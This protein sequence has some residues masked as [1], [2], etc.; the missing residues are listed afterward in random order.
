M[1]K[2]MKKNGLILFLIMAALFLV[3]PETNAMLRQVTNPSSDAS[4]SGSLPWAVAQINAGG[5]SSNTIW[6]NT[7]GDSITVYSTLVINY[8]TT[9][10]SIA[11][12][13][14]TI[15]TSNPNSMELFRGNTNN[16]NFY[17]LNIVDS[18][19]GIHIMPGVWNCLIYGCRIGTDETNAVNR[20]NKLYGIL[21]EGNVTNIGQ[22]DAGVINVISN[23][24]TAGIFLRKADK[25]LIRNS[26]IGTNN[27]GTAALG[28]Q[29]YGVL[30]QEGAV[31]CRIGGNYYYY[32]GN[33][34]SGN[35]FGISI[36]DVSSNTC[37][38]NS[39]AGNIIGLRADQSAAIPNGTGVRLYRCKENSVGAPQ[40][41]N[42]NVISGNSNT[43]VLLTDGSGG[44]RPNGNSISNNFIGT[45]R[46]GEIR[47][48]KTGIEIINGD[49]NQIGGNRQG[50]GPNVVAGNAG[51]G[52]Q[53]GIIIN[54]DNNNIIG[55][56]V[57]VYMNTVTAIANSPRAIAVQ[58]NC[59][60]IGD[61]NDAT[62]SYGNIISGN[63]N[64]GVDIISGIGN[65]IYGNYIGLRAD[66][67]EEVP[68]GNTG[69]YLWPGSTL[70]QVGGF[71]PE[72]A[73]A[74]AGN[75]YG[76]ILD[77]TQ[78]NLV[79]GNTLDASALGTISIKNVQ[80]S[81]LL[82]NGADKNWLQEN[83]IGNTVRLQD[84]QNNTIVANWIGM[85]PNKTPAGAPLDSGIYLS[86]SSGNCIG[87][88]G[89][90]S[91]SNLIT[92]CVNGIDIS[93]SGSV[94]NRVFSNTITAFSGQGIY[95]HNGGNNERFTPYITE[96]SLLGINGYTLPNDFV[97]LFH[98][99]SRPGGAGGSIKYLSYAY[100]DVF[101]YFH[102]DRQ[103]YNTGYY[104]AVAAT[105]GSGN[106]SAFSK[107]AVVGM[108]IPSRTVTPT[109]TITTTATITRTYTISPTATN[110]PTITPTPTITRT[111]TITPTATIT[112]TI[113]PTPTITITFT[114]SPTSTITPTF[115]I[116]PTW[117][118]S[119]TISPTATITPTVNETEAA[120][121][122]TAIVHETEVANITAT[123]IA[124]ETAI[125]DL[126]KG[127]VVY[128]GDLKKK[129]KRAFVYPST[130]KGW[131]YFVL[132]LDQP[133]EVKI[134]IYNLNGE[135]I[136]K[137]GKYLAVGEILPWDC[138]SVARGLYFARISVDGRVCWIV[139]LALLK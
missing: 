74:I 20:G 28:I 106:S 11:S 45:T 95:L 6:I 116:S 22:N 81:I 66:G 125:T 84:S 79:I 137:L 92:N 110:S 139:K 114:I 86:N 90:I 62:D 50:F 18:Y 44:V 71:Y 14:V 25:C 40:P 135:E 105:D 126:T 89:D 136:A 57:G 117:S 103:G 134:C 3:I 101:G 121:T 48:N 127:I 37:S 39:I 68:N 98:A 4:T 120:E 8:P 72:R 41:A 123:A 76:I 109:R 88:P 100:A 115:T 36:E 23:N 138:R 49:D 111:F 51:S 30:L 130:M 29:T 31:N 87:F 132:D 24:A 104:V 17:K 129:G 113:T 128:P 43:G 96:A 102:I 52:N 46:M 16:C 64:N 5:E 42:E 27:E 65:S 107:N 38:G 12:D 70:S 69:I 85:L 35:T 9:V 13:H 93:D 15:G 75:Q 2:R 133:G 55:N 73:N 97:E 53:G 83:C 67:T 26:Y 82:E 1:G 7:S 32:E 58:G 47:P 59:N 78:N 131:M 122:A 91:A 80:A 54:G 34:I 33:V 10:Q 21:D 56:Y 119:P 99:E 108:I 94:N 118:P 63:A 19:I 77:G 61:Y 112:P 124:R 60:K